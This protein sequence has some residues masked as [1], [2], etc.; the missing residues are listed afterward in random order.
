MKKKRTIGLRFFYFNNAALTGRYVYLLLLCRTDGRT[1]TREASTV[2]LCW[3][4]QLDY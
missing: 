3:G 4:Y 2:Q 1:G